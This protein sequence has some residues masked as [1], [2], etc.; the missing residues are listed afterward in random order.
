VYDVDMLENPDGEPDI[1]QVLVNY[2]TT[3]GGSVAYATEL[4]EKTE[5]GTV[6]ATLPTTTANTGYRFVNWTNAEGEVVTTETVTV[7]EDT[8]FTANFELIDITIT[9]NHVYNG[10]RN[11]EAASTT[12]VD[13]VK[14]GA[15]YTYTPNLNYNNVTYVLSSNNATVSGQATENTVITFVYDVDMISS[16][17]TEN[18]SVDS[19]V[20]T[21]GPDGVADWKQVIFTYNSAG[22]GAVTGTV[23]EI[24]TLELSANGNDLIAT[25]PIANVQTN[26]NSGYYV[27]TNAWVNYGTLAAIRAQNFN[28]DQ[29]F[30]ATFA[31]VET[32]VTPVTPE[33]TT[34]T[35]PT[36][37]TTPTPTTTTTTIQNEE[38]PLAVAPVTPVAQVVAPVV[39]IEEEEVP[40]VAEPDD[41]DLS[42]T[43][44]VTIE[45]EEVPLATAPINA[46][47]ALLNLLLA[48]GT[49]LASII[50]LIAYFGKKKKEEE[51]ENAE[52]DETVKKKG[53]V[54]LISL[55]PAVGSIVAFILTENMANPMVFMDQW[56]ILMVCIALVQIVVCLFAKKEKKEKEDTVNA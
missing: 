3:E 18:G 29:N 11:Y 48:I 17:V 49:T 37:P 28:N 26:A 50:L 56:T 13:V 33:T 27:P 42:L 30:V 35:A 52:E 51:E 19:N 31:Q 20:T 7:S 5:A 8:T 54:R 46:S 44:E 32:P 25:N 6:T 12:S 23:I 4:L 21:N 1:N 40:L 38:V 22:N 24:H 43:P 53:I 45:E 34:P 9:V 16:N 15:E 39:E 47:W 55:I 36:T 14:Y 2:E 41:Q 10:D